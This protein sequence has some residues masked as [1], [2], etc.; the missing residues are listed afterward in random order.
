MKV[1]KIYCQDPNLKSENKL[2]DDYNPADFQVFDGTRG[3]KLTIV[4]KTEGI[5][6]I[7]DLK[8]FAKKVDVESMEK[9]AL[10]LAKCE[11]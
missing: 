8:I 10:N 3:S 4:P 1:M 7:C 5:L 6:K 9:Y 2:A 11:V